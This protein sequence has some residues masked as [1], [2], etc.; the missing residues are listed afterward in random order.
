MKP[1]IVGITGGIGSGKSVVSKVINTIGYPVYDADGEA[2]A[3]LDS[4]VV[5]KD[6]VKSLLGEKAFLANG[7]PDRTYISTAVFGNAQLLQSLNAIIHPAV[8]EHFRQWVLK[9]YSN[10]LLFK[11][12]AIMFESGS[13]KLMDK[14]VGVVAPE[15]IRINRVI[16]RDHKTEEAIRSIIARQ[17]PTAELTKKCDYV[18]ENDEHQLVIPQ[19][20]AI[21]D[22]LKEVSGNELPI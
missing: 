21:I 12:A 2:A 7:L 3:I 4:D 15:E 20:L 16:A 11:E 22:Q 17:L 1:F 8:H 5:V 18:I 19:V 6:A 10:K 9:N 14:I 13:Y